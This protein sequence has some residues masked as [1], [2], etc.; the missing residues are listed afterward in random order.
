MRKQ[1]I[2]L[3]HL[4]TAADTAA[5]PRDPRIY[6]DLPDVTTRVLRAMRSK[7]DCRTRNCEQREQFAFFHR[8]FTPFTADGFVEFLTT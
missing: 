4:F 7:V 8:R 6:Q 1:R 2:R 3:E 5:W